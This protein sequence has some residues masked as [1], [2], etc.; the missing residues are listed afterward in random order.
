MSSGPPVPGSRRA[1]LCWSRVES[2]SLVALAFRNSKLGNGKVMI[3]P[4]MVSDLFPQLEEDLTDELW[5]LHAS[6]A[7]GQLP[8]GLVYLRWRG[9]KSE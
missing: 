4:D 7:L 8:Y 5:L 9:G 3:D 2:A 1:R 6:P